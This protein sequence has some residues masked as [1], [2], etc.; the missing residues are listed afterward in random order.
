MDG[1]ER[2]PIFENNDSVE[3]ARIPNYRQYEFFQLGRLA[4]PFRTFSLC[5]SQMNSWS[6][7]R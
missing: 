3:T 4:L 6:V 1:V 5:G 2:A 7:I